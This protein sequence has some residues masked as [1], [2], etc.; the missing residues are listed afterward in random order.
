MIRS[1]CSP[2]IGLY[3][4][5]SLKCGVG[6]LRFLNIY[7]AEGELDFDAEG[8]VDFDAEGEL[9]GELDTEAEGEL[10]IDADGEA[11]YSSRT[12]CVPMSVMRV[13]TYRLVIA[14][15]TALIVAVLLIVHLTGRSAEAVPIHP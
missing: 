4:G 2:V 1:A 14:L 13:T 10:E 11:E 8:D 9:D 15:L 5:G 3:G 7:D 6:C 12:S